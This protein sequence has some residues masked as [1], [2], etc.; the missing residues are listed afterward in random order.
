MTRSLVL[1]LV[2]SGLLACSGSATQIKDDAGLP[3]AAPDVR[4][5]DAALD[6]APPDMRPP[7][8]TVDAM[9]PCD[10]AACGV[11][12]PPEICAVDTSPKFQT[13]LMTF[14]FRVRCVTQPSPLFRVKGYIPKQGVWDTFEQNTGQGTLTVE[15]N[16]H[17]F[18]LNA[19]AID[20]TTL[21]DVDPAE[22]W[23]VYLSS[24]STGYAMV[25][26]KS[27]KTA[28]P[29]PGAAPPSSV[30]PAILA[31]TIPFSP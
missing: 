18:T 29:I 11:Q 5:L 27:E 2:G 16:V 9:L 15:N 25:L 4:L 3:D 7:D 28:T 1:L 14:S 21:S 24:G 6:A 20:E 30:P 26:K 22:G 8:T 19:E 10:P 23:F 13:T 17:R 31:A 12:S